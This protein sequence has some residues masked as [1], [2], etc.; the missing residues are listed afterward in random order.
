MFKK[1]IILGCGGQAKVVTDIAM[2]CGY[3]DIGFLDDFFTDDT[4]INF[5][6]L[7][8]CVDAEKY[9]S[10]DF[11]IA[12][13]NSQIRHKIQTQLIEKG[14]NIATLT[15]PSAIIAPDVTIGHGTVVM[16]GVVI[17]PSAKIGKGCIINTC[18]SIDHDCTIGDFAHISVGAHIAGTVN[19]GNNTWIGVGAT[20]SNNIN[21]VA[22]CMVGAGAVVVEDL[23]KAGTYVGV[24]AKNIK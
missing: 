13:G 2:K 5:P 19:I 3:Q 12:I 14:L 23:T 6:V 1:L 20:V 4:F 24:P 16:A 17:N 22:D 7:G 18:A 15:H 8:K 10:A 9:S 21:I 11:F